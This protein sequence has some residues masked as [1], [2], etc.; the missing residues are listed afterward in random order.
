MVWVG[1]PNVTTDLWG[2]E[3]FSRFSFSNETAYRYWRVHVTN[4]MGGA[5]MGIV[6]IEMMENL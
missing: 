2:G 4:N 1:P 6:E 5:E 3:P